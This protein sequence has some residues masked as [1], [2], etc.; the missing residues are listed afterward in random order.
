MTTGTNMASK[1]ANATLQGQLASGE[2]VARL[3]WPFCAFSGLQHYKPHRYKH[4][5]LFIW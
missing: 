2:P 1:A 4:K 5:A 3:G